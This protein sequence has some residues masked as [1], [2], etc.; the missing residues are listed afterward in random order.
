[1]RV[2]HC[3]KDLYNTECHSSEDWP[4]TKDYPTYRTWV[5]DRL[6]MTKMTVEKKEDCEYPDFI[7]ILNAATDKYLPILNTSDYSPTICDSLAG[8][9]MITTPVQYVRCARQNRSPNDIAA[10]VLSTIDAVTWISLDF[11]IYGGQDKKCKTGSQS[12]A[13][14]LIP[15]LITF[16]LE[17]VGFAVDV[18]L[19]RRK[20]KREHG[21][22]PKTFSWIGLCE[23][24]LRGFGMPFLVAYV[25][26]PRSFEASALAL[27]SIFILKP[28]A[29]PL[30]AIPAKR[31]LGTGYGAQLLFVDSLIAVSGI[32][33]A[34]LAGLTWIPDFDF[35]FSGPQSARTMHIGLWI[36]FLPLLVI[37]VIYNISQAFYLVFL[38]IGLLVYWLTRNSRLL[39]WAFSILLFWWGLVICFALSPIFALFELGWSI[40]CS[41]K[42]L[43]G[44]EKVFPLAKFFAKF[45]DSGSGHWLM[46]IGKRA[47]YYP[48]CILMVAVFVGRWMAL[49][50]L[51]AIAGDAFCPASWTEA[52]VAYVF[53]TLFMIVIPTTLHFFG[54]SL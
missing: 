1:M 29:T 43:K 27:V 33:I 51:M 31:L 45:F 15:M 6:N 34:V 25:V 21:E 5:R 13:A 49:V 37:Y 18:W 20:C 10:C 12:F 28:R 16:F 24:L 54:L 30:I 50:N 26:Y 36:T 11:F 23:K 52:A 2:A 4:H 38:G 48:W 44:H 17:L 40:H 53:F 32:F 8:E 39:K 14:V 46:R 19:W 42:K 41:R 47:F 35:I 22:P 3:V 7:P 9:V